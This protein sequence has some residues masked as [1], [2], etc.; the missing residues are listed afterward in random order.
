MAAGGE[1]HEGGRSRGAASQTGG[2]GGDSEH[3]SRKRQLVTQAC[4]WLQRAAM[5]YSV[6][7]ISA[8]SQADS[9]AVKVHRILKI[10]ALF[11]DC[12]HAVEAEEFAATSQIVLQQAGLKT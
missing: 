2:A 9:K 7:A 12:G 3:R 5:G 4:A 10:G 11:F 1:R 6:I 8:N